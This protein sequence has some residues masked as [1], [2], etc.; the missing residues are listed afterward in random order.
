MKNQRI[1]ITF[2]GMLYFITVNSGSADLE[3]IPQS[4][5]AVIAETKTND[6]NGISS[7]GDV[8]QAIREAFTIDLAVKNISERIPYH[9]SLAAQ[10]GTLTSESVKSMDR[11]LKVM[12]AGTHR[13]MKQL[14]QREEYKDKEIPFEEYLSV[15]NQNVFIKAQEGSRYRNSDYLTFEETNWFK[16]DGSPEKAKVYQVQT[17][18]SNLISDMD[19]AAET[20]INITDFTNIVAATGAAVEDF[21]TFFVAAENIERSIVDM[22]ILRYPDIDRPYFKLFRIKL[23]AYRM[24]RRI[25]A[26][27]RDESGIKGVYDTVSYVPRE[28]VISDLRESIRDMAVSEAEAMFS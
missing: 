18:F 24:C 9:T 16:F 20:Q 25:L 6:A 14:Q 11:K 4:D 23:R 7:I 8:L 21:I 27:Q 28:E 12:I 5:N 15:M 3:S 13:M 10:Y 19:V 2:L 26:G 1:L 17:W 22:G